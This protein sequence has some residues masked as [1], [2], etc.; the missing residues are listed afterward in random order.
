MT[1]VGTGGSIETRAVVCKFLLNSRVVEHFPSGFF[2]LFTGLGIFSDDG[3]EDGPMEIGPG[4]IFTPNFSCDII[5]GTYILLLLIEKYLILL[6]GS[7][8]ING[9]S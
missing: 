1:A 3:I 6:G 2:T 5:L 8:K 9:F 4:N 7:I